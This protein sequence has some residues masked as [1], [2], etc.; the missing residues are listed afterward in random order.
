MKTK[1]NI[2]INPKAPDYLKD[3]IQKAL[4]EANEVSAEEMKESNDE[5]QIAELEAEIEILYDMMA[6]DR[7]AVLVEAIIAAV[8]K[9]APDQ[10]LSAD[11]E[12]MAESNIAAEIGVEEDAAFQRARRGPRSHF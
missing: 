6:S 7:P 1:P 5:I 10:T 2:Y 9:L 3:I 11:I 12:T 8:E 4:P